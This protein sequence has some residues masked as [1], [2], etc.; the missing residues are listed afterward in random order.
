MNGNFRKIFLLITLKLHL[1]QSLSINCLFQ[2]YSWN[3]LLGTYYCCE[4][5]NI[6]NSEINS[7]NVTEITGQHQSGRDNNDVRFIFF[8]GWTS[9][10]NQTFIPRGLQ[11]FFPNT[12]M[13]IFWRAG[14]SE[15]FADDLVNFPKLIHFELER[16]P[17]LSIPANFFE[18]NLKLERVKMY[19]IN[20]LRH[21]GENL[22][23]NLKNL[24]I[25]D[26]R[27][28]G[29]VREI[30]EG[31]YEIHELNQRLHILCPPLET[32]T[33]T[34]SIPSSTTTTTTTTSIPSSTTTAKITTTV[35][36]S[37][38]N[39]ECPNSCSTKIEAL[40][41]DIEE[42]KKRLIELEKVVRELTVRP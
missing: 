14:I 12:V 18:R 11:F 1:I 21:V 37:T 9:E 28:S 20:S 32:T 34:T 5:K 25:A 27:F 22:L 19:A 23:G 15:L 26:F 30:A 8:N 31:Q 42:Y 36:S 2:T 24:T 16:G 39:E 3:N 13:I 17:I 40:E 41:E 10:I 33:T 4:V 6:T 35:E 29:C 38:E 7:V